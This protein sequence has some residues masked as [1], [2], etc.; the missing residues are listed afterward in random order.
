MRWKNATK[1]VSL[2]AGIGLV[3]MGALSG[4]GGAAKPLHYY[5]LGSVSETQA[6]PGDVLN[7]S[8][9]VRRFMGS[10]LLRDDRIVYG[11]DAHDLELYETR[12]WAMP[13]VDLLQD[14]LTRDLRSTGRFRMVTML[15]SDL[16]TDYALSGQLYDFREFNS[17]SGVFARL[18]YDLELR[19]LKQGRTIW[20]HSYSHDEQSTGKTVSDLV[21]AM[22]KNVKRSVDEIQDGI[23]QAIVAN[24]AKNPQ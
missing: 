24:M 11:T 9:V 13:P 1:R 2:V 23:I 16:S 19:D 3:A 22:D 17:S 15:R 7:A 8:L 4:C 10:H 12:R 18:N 5:Q 14:R 21:E 20:K 6:Q